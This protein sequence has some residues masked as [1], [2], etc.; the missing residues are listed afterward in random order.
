MPKDPA[1]LI[2]WACWSSS[3]E[4]SHDTSKGIVFIPTDFWGRLST[5]SYSHK[6]DRSMPHSVRSHYW[7][8]SMS[9]FIPR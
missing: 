5:G 8:D 4:Q 6:L 2:S 9:E 7:W 1:A 3:G